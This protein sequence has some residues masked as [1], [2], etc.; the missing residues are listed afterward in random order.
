M[1]VDNNIHEFIGDVLNGNKE[2]VSLSQLCN[3]ARTIL[4][5][6]KKIKRTRKCL[7]VNITDMCIWQS[8]VLKSGTDSKMF[9]FVS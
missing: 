4:S 2:R 6:K 3:S 1:H 7:E 5:K 9:E 8:G